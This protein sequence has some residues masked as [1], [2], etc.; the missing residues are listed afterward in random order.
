MI[1]DLKCTTCGHTEERFYQS[2]KPVCSKCGGETE[3]LITANWSFNFKDGRGTDL[4]LT[5]SYP[6]G[7]KQIKRG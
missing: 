3:K 1:A 7:Y 2:T 4:G 5:T 6:S